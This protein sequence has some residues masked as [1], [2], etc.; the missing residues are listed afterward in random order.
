MLSRLKLNTQ[1]YVSFGLV[2]MLLAVISIT[3]LIGFNRINEDF[4]E[5]RGL[6]RDTNLAGRVQAN[7]LMMRLAV[8]NYVNTQSDTSVAQYEERKSKMFDFLNEAEREIQKPERAALVKNIVSEVDDYEHGFEQVVKL[9]G[10]RNQIVKQQ[11]DPNGLSMRKALSDIIISAYD[12]NDAE[13]SFYAAQLQEHLLLARLYV[14][15]YLVTNSSEDAGRAKQELSDKMPVF[16]NKL[17]TSLQN[18]ARRALLAQVTDSHS[19][20]VAA[21]NS[22]EETILSRNNLIDNTLNTIGP[23]VASDIEK[24][25][26]SVKGEQDALGPKVQTDTENGLFIVTITSLSAFLLGAAIAV[27]MPRVIRKPIGGEPNDI[28]EITHKVA[29]GDL[30]QNLVV[31]ESDSGIYKAI[32][33]MNGRLRTVIGTLVDTNRSLTDSATRSASIASENVNT[34]AYQKQTTEQIVVAVEEMSQS[35]NEV[36]DLARRSE[37]K[38]REGMAH[39]TEGRDVLKHALESVNTLAE[40]MQSSMSAIKNLEEKNAD[41]VSVLDVIGSISEQTNLLALNAAIEAARAGEAGRGFA[42]VADEVRTLASRTQESTAEIQ[43][44]IDSLQKGTQEVVSVMETSTDLANDTVDK[45][46]QTDQALEVIY[47]T[48]NEISEMNTLVATAVSQQSVAAGEVTQNMTEI[49]NTIEKTMSAASE[50]HNASEDVMQM[51]GQIGE[52]TS[53]FKV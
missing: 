27:F 13:A 21:F 1:L 14:T 33:G 25:K 45:S 20:Y 7:M 42:V 31:K 50:A 34:V 30:S 44:I 40:G 38:S 10:E 18:P 35:I 39:A 46:N 37:D 19:K 53:R 24:V 2:L 23:I 8:L 26:L 41:I 49:R 52:I 47:Q 22:V 5:Y 32:C 17:D 4:V 28:A 11:L 43:K 36:S 29:D 6:A 48:I 12:D 15:K 9:F 16:L 3:S 51:A